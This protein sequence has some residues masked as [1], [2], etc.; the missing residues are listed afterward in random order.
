MHGMIVLIS[1]VELRII[2]QSR[3]CIY[4]CII[5]PFYIDDLGGMFF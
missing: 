1:R 3:D 4:D 5:D 2:V